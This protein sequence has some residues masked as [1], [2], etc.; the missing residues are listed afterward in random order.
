MPKLNLS[1]NTFEVKP[2]TTTKTITNDVQTTAKQDVV[3]QQASA[4]GGF[5]NKQTSQALEGPVIIFRDILVHNIHVSI[6]EY[7]KKMKMF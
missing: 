4:T 3:L 7:Q 2:T 6:Q 1:A 5:G